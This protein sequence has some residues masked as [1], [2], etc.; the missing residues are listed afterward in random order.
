[1][2]N[3][4]LSKFLK[5]N[6]TRRIQ[7]ANKAGYSSVEDYIDFLNGVTGK[8]KKI[9]TIH[10]V[11]ILDASGSMGGGK[12]DNALIG[13]NTEIK[14]LKKDKNT[15]YI[16]TLV[17]FSNYYDIR[18]P[19]FMVP[20]SNI[21]HYSAVSRN[22]TALNQA[23]GETLDKLLLSVDKKDK[24]LVKI[25][26]DG[27]ENN[28]QYP[29]RMNSALARKIKE[30]EDKGFTIT[31]VGTELDVN[32]VVQNLNINISNT[33]VHDN[34]SAGVTNAFICSTAST[35]LYSKKVARGKDVSREFYSKE[36]GKI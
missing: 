33:L 20:I 16:Q 23:V 18:T 14:L 26:T 28:S 24:V 10:N 5:N 12:L 22:M 15:N 11:Y 25:F 29:Y 35:Q 9:P 3:E 34:T 36:V 13:I 2:T 8:R 17:D 30:C 32:D 6:K 4:N 7:V 1:M 31:F 21:S 27:K 19:Y